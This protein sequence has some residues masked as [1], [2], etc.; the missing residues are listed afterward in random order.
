MASETQRRIPS[1]YDEP[2]VIE[3]AADEEVLNVLS[4]RQLMVRRFLK[5]RLA[6]LGLVILLVMYTSVIFADF[7]APY[8]PTHRFSKFIH[9]PPRTIHL[10][11]AE[12]T[13][14]AR[15]STGWKPKLIGSISS[16]FSLRIPSEF[17]RFGSL[18]AG[19][20]IGCGG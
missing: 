17:T 9:T 6:V 2:G 18:C 12:A 10:F 5:S 20:R 1:P 14:A 8:S 11:D 19:T 16:A 3:F 4:P 13:G 7:I 15:S